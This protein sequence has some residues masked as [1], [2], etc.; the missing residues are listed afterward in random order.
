MK[1]IVVKL[2]GEIVQS[3]EL[4]LIAED[5]KQLIDGWNRVTIVH[6][7]GPQATALQKTLGL[8]PRMIAGR[9]YTDPATLDVMKYVLAGQLNVDLCA[10]LLSR[11]VMPVGLH[12]AS[13]HMV[14][15][16][17]RPPRV[18][19]GAGPDPVDLGLV[20]DVTGFNL[21]LLGDLFER[22]YVPVIACLGCDR[23]GQVLN[24]NGDT[25]ASQLA[26]A[27][28]ADALVLVTST[29]GVLR[30]VKDPASRIGRIDRAEFER[31]V[32]DGTISG[33]MIPKLEES[34]E[35]LAG[36]AKSVVIIGKLAAGDL[37]RAVTQPGS[38]GTVLEA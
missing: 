5:L 15:A 32:K 8:E 1:T 19:Q 3:P 13:G 14:Q 21:P 28:R 31:L 29:P 22:R 2:G 7:G 26:G 35:I 30:D 9:R 27:L 17:R 11:G 16:T 18:M 4:D 12:G 6:G 37:L 23:E 24:I 33:G 25:V 20:G 38:A 34:F 10:R 36:G